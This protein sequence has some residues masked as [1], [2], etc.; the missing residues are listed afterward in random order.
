[1][2][3]DR[4]LVISSLLSILLIT[5]HLTGDVLRAKPGNPETG[6]STLVTVPFLALW[7]YATLVFPHRRFSQ[8]L[9]LLLALAAIGMPVIHAMGPSGFF[10]G[11]MAK[12]NG[13]D[14]IFVWGL[15][16]LGVTGIFS[17]ALAIQALLT[18]QASSST[19]PISGKGTT[20]SRADNVPPFP[21]A[22]A[23]E[24]NRFY[25]RATLSLRAGL[26]QQ[27]R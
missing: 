21:S 2:K 23:A 19:K 4:L 20:S 9:M 17:L 16:L 15:H 7:L 13:G 18:P 22:L 5:L 6:G 1:M 27:G 25:S 26:R 10:T 14:F 12:G 11:Q 24:V 8:L 3:N